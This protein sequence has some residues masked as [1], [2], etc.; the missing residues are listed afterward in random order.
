MPPRILVLYNETGPPA[1]PPRRQVRTRHPRHHRETPPR[2]SRPPGF[3]VERLGINYDPQPLLDELRRRRRPDAVFNLFRGARHP[4]RHRGVRRR[5]AGV[6]ER[7]VHRVAVAGPVRR[8]RQDPHQAPARRRRAPHPGSNL[9]IDQ[10][11]APRWVGGVAGDCQ[12]RPAG[13]QRRHRAGERRHV[14]GA[15]GGA[16]PVRPWAPTARRCWS[17]GSSPAGS[18]TSTW[19]RT[20]RASATRGR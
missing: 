12:A 14:A 13:R 17:S 15:T 3:E 10:V 18:S 11:P 7:P 16:D 1:G 19:S 4:D 9:V 5:A 8:P 20:G 6:A 2:C